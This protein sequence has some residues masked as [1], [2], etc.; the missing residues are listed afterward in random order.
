MCAFVHE[1]IRLLIHNLLLLQ[2]MVY[3]VRMHP[4]LVTTS[5]D[6]ETAPSRFVFHVVVIP[7]FG[8]LLFLREFDV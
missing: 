6:A 3:S 1:N 5:K 4:Q 7:S 8:A 2:P